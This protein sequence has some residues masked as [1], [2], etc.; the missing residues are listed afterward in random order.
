MALWIWRLYEYID[1]RW[2][3]VAQQLIEIYDLKADAKIL[4]VGCGKAFLLYELKNNSCLM[5]Q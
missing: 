1:D 3:K 2:K 4:D 5:Q